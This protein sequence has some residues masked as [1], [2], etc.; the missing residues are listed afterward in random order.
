[1][2]SEAG[3]SDDDEEPPALVTAEP[4]VREASPVVDT[5]PDPGSVPVT[6]LTGFLGSGKTTLLRHILTANHGKR[7]AVI[8]NEFGDSM[9]IEKLIAEDGASASVLLAENIL[10]LKNGCICCTVKDD[11]V[12]GLET[13]LTQRSKFDYIIIE[14]T[15]MANPGPV[16]GC[17]W[18]DEALGSA[19]QLDAIVTVVDLKHIIQHLDGS[20]ENTAE[21]A[22]QIAYADRLLLNKSDLV[23][24]DDIAIVRQKISAINSECEMAVTQRCS[25]ELDWILDIGC[26]SKESPLEVKDVSSIS[27]GCVDVNHNHNGHNH[28]DSSTHSHTRAH[29]VHASTPCS[30]TAGVTTISVT[31]TEELSLSR[32]EAWIGGLLWEKGQ[33]VYRIKGVI[34][35]AGSPYKHVLQGV[36]EVFDVHT[37][38]VAWAQ[39]ESKL[40]K[41]VLIGRELDRDEAYLGLKSCANALS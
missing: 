38:S 1:M 3:E 6:I 25:I 28:S 14:T 40:S 31:V 19:L 41:V 29:D 22:Q 5:T 15:G 9:D 12:A 16:A 18:L 20:A 23:T 37:S 33:K 27:C 7:I 26:Y 13:L 2:V 11:L 8:E 10:E 21:A 30:H 32:L 17:F 4:L 34:C 39:G 35:I 36:H 24:V